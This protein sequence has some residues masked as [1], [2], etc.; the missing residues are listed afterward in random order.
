MTHALTQ[1]FGSQAAEKSEGKSGASSPRPA[2][3]NLTCHSFD[4]SAQH[5]HRFFHASELC[6]NKQASPTITPG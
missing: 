2:C 3:P 4:F 5:F 6:D 1:L